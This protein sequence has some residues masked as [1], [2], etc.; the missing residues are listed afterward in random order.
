VFDSPELF[1]DVLVG[2]S[3][4]AGDDRFECFFIAEDRSNKFVD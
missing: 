1:I 3:D 2:L 4:L